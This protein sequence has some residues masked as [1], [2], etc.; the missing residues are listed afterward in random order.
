VVAGS[1]SYTELGQKFSVRDLLEPEQ[2]IRYRRLAT[3]AQRTNFIMKAARAYLNGLQPIVAAAEGGRTLRSHIVYC[4]SDAIIIWDASRDLPN[5]EVILN[6]PLRALVS[7]P[8]GCWRPWD[9][10][11]NALKEHQVLCVVQMLRDSFV[12]RKRVGM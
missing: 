12:R 10:H 5:T 2:S 1:E 8:D 11:P 6:R 3:E 9:L 7:I 4:A